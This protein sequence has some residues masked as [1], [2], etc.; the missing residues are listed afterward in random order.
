MQKSKTQLLL[1]DLLEKA[2][3]A[4]EIRADDDSARSGHTISVEKYQHL[5]RENRNFSIEDRYARRVYAPYLQ[6]QAVRDQILK[7]IEAELLEYRNDEMA[8]RFLLMSGLT[9]LTLGDAGFDSILSSLLRVALLKG[10]EYAVHSFYKSIKKEPIPFQQMAL[11]DGLEV[12]H[13]VQIYDGVRLIPLP[14]STANLPDYLPTP[15]APWRMKEDPV[16]EDANIFR[17]ATIMSIDCCARVALRKPG[18]KLFEDDDAFLKNTF[19]AKWEIMSAELGRLGVRDMGSY[20][21]HFRQFYRLLSLVCNHA[22]GI[23][24]EWGYYDVCE[25][26]VSPD[27][28]IPLDPSISKNPDSKTVTEWEIAAAKSLHG[29]FLRINSDGRKVLQTALSRWEMAK[30][31]RNQRKDQDCWNKVDQMIDLGIAFES[32]YLGG[33][34]KGELA[35]T[36]RTRAAWLLGENAEERARILREFKVIYDCRSKAVHS[37]R[38]EDP[39]KV[40]KGSKIPLDEFLARA[41]Y[42]CAASIKKIIER[43]GFPDWDKL[44]TGN[45]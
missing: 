29:Q 27:A 13:E 16:L 2:I 43:G 22:M 28:S 38:L 34:H 7:L 9:S 10:S 32:L 21:M 37:G 41:Q 5:H 15:R 26:F 25:V 31:R 30:R 42:R 8:V 35:F 1:E 33:D 45:E 44:I 12:A 11:I 40:G 17:S 23:V 4:T 20:V 39:I 6:N 24:S 36:L 18:E 3:D 14:P 19:D